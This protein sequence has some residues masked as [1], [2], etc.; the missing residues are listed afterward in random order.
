[1]TQGVRRLRR[2]DGDLCFSVAG[3]GRHVLLL[4][5]WTLDRRM[6][7]AQVAAFARR[8]AVVTVDRR[9]FGESTAP[10]DL[11]L[12]IGDLEAL[13][14]AVGCAWWA[15]VGMSQ[16]GRIALRYGHRHPERLW[17]MVLQS[18]PL[19]GFA[20]PP[21][22]E[23]IPLDSYRQLVAAGR[24]G[25]VKRAWSEH[26]H[27]RVAPGEAS[28]LLAAMLESY[29]GRDLLGRQGAPAPAL[30]PDLGALDIPALVVTGERDTPWLQS[31]G[32]ELARR[33]PRPQRVILAD[34]GHLS[35]LTHPLA[36]NAAVLAF[37]DH[38]ASGDA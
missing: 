26:P 28:G 23:A 4:H 9:G 33:L 13:R 15:V 32:D 25:A 18:A 36:F 29:A 24:L 27:M 8:Y 38:Q 17:A 7:R 20:P 30:G 11:D 1:M 19:D 5:G 31:V 16:G 14:E 12:E 22:E 35:N 3:A 6:W 2:P 37:L 34:A 10:P 21:A